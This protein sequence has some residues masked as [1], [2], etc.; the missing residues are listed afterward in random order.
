MPLT[1]SLLQRIPHGSDARVPSNVC[2]C[3]T[4]VWAFFPVFFNRV[5]RY[6]II[7]SVIVAVMGS[8]RQR[9]AERSLL[10]TVSRAQR[11]FFVLVQPQIRSL[12]ICCIQA[13]YDDGMMG[14]AK[15]RLLFLINAPPL[16]RTSFLGPLYAPI[17]S[18]INSKPE[19]N[20]RTLWKQDLNRPFSVPAFTL[21]G[22]KCLHL[23]FKL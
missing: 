19:D 22:R 14:L 1:S 18:L 21:F 7:C 11:L 23:Q 13:L 20:L 16:L 17:Y 9:E 10:E 5:L 15:K 8:G 2:L 3:L 6:T 12:G 4:P